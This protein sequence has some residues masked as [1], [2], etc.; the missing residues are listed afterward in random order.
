MSDATFDAVLRRQRDDAHAAIVELIARV[1]DFDTDPLDDPTGY[2]AG[3]P[4]RGAVEHALEAARAARP[5]LV[6][7]DRDVDTVEDLGRSLLAAGVELELEARQMPH[8]D[9][10]NAHQG[11]A[12]GLQQAAI[13]VRDFVDRAGANVTLSRVS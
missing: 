5:R 7:T 2:L 3:G 12:L 1:R 4:A 11:R 6:P 8:P 9:M 10:V 13:R